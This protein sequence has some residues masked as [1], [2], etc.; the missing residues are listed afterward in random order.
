MKALIISNGDMKDINWLSEIAMDF[1]FIL[2]ADGGCNYCI[3]AN[4][5]PDLV[6]GD[7]DSISIRTLD[8]LNKEGIPVTKY[9]VKKNATDTELALDILI[10][11]GIKDITFVG[12]IGS[13]MDHTLANILLL[14]KLHEKG[15][16]GKIM[17]EKNTIYLVD[18][19]LILSK[20]EDSY[21][22][23]I[24][25]TQKGVSISLKGFEY[26]LKEYTINFGS[27]LG[28]SN[29]IIHDKAY[30]LVHEGLCLVCLSRD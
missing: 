26:E 12:A 30:I 15:C 18:K 17:D 22:S 20:K 16:T 3:E 10:D 7:L 29:K 13:R 5:L 2:C 1:D 4:I 9:P 25:L 24:P 6:I 19:E 28:I 23:V 14:I 11:K 8:I 21:V 27:T